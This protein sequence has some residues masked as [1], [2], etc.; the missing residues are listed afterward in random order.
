MV[1]IGGPDN[2]NTVSATINNQVNSPG[3]TIG[4]ATDPEVQDLLQFNYI[5]SDGNYVNTIG[6]NYIANINV[7]ASTFLTLNNTTGVF[8][9]TKNGEYLLS[10]AFYLKASS[11]HDT[12]WKTGVLPDGRFDISIS[13]GNTSS[14]DIFTGASKSIVADMDSDII[15]TAQC[16]VQLTTVD[17]VM[18]RMLN[19]SGAN[20]AGGAYGASD[21]IR[22]GIVKLRDL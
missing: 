20:Y 6:T 11:N 4:I 17:E 22:V 7:P 13:S 10:V 18:F 1:K 15:L 3:L 9:I 14:N 8:S 5:D 2:N 19:L 12:Y 16:V 21:V